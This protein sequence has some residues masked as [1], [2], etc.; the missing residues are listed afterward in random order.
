M[1]GT[2][3]GSGKGILT[4]RKYIE[5][6]D[7]DHIR[8]ILSSLFASIPYTTTDAPFEHYFQTVIY[9]VFTLLDQFTMCEM[10]TWQGRIDCI[11]Q[12][13]RFIYLFEF[14]RDSNADDAL[15][16][17]EE[18]KYALPFAADPRKIF[19]IG[20]SFDSKTRMLA[21]WKVLE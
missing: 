7:T 15:D 12:A 6:G 13:R 17:I 4:L 9:L 19:R 5:N 14:K 3:A 8:D 20:V 2:G 21:D 11:V 1:R 10:H 18:M 16:Q